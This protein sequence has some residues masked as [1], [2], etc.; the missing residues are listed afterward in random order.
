MLSAQSKESASTRDVKINIRAQTQQRQ[1]IDQAAEILGKTRSDFM[2]EAA[3]Q[4]AENVLLD[5]RTFFLDDDKWQD[6][7]NVLDTPVKSNEKLQKFL[8]T[9]APW[10]M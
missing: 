7:L 8:N 2:L 4:K 10:E 6:F 1:L 3:C 9:S 5:Q